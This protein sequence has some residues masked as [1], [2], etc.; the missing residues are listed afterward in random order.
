MDRPVDVCDHRRKINSRATMS[1]EPS[2]TSLTTAFIVADGKRLIAPRDSVG[3]AR[4]RE[5]DHVG[6]TDD[7]TTRA[8]NDAMTSL[9]ATVSKCFRVAHC[10]QIRRHP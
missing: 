9:A 5:R 7:Q 2:V 1:A 10:V 6:A 3:A 8:H 4:F